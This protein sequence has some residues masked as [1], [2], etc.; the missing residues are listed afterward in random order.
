MDRRWTCQRCHCNAMKSATVLHGCYG[1]KYAMKCNHSKKF[2]LFRRTRLKMIRILPFWKT[3]END[4]WFLGSTLVWGQFYIFAFLTSF[5]QIFLL[6]CC[7]EQKIR[8]NSV[9]N[10]KIQNWSLIKIDLKIDFRALLD[11]LG[12]RLVWLFKAKYFPTG[13]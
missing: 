8:Q 12:L 7:A 9:R 4:R 10:A 6:F 3:R 11:S 1:Q 2:M 13:I 5:W